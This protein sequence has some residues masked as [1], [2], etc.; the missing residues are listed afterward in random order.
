M[1]PSVSRRFG[2][3]TELFNGLRARKEVR[4]PVAQ[5]RKDD[6]TKLAQVGQTGL[7]L[8]F[9]AVPWE[10]GRPSQNMVTLGSSQILNLSH[11][12][13]DIHEYTATGLP[14]GQKTLEEYCDN[15]KSPPMTRPS[16][17]PQMQKALGIPY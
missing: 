8:Y 16:T 6:I 10:T 3:T 11:L 5:I 17:V 4:P 14:G 12:C 13:A 1:E 15:Y 2:K 9:S 7:L